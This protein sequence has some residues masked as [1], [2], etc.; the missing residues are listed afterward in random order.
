M[1]LS[2]NETRDTSTKVSSMPHFRNHACPHHMYVTFLLSV[3]SAQSID[4]TRHIEFIISV[5]KNL[6]HASAPP[7]QSLKLTKRSTILLLFFL[8]F[9]KGHT[10]VTA[11]LWS[12]LWQIQLDN[13]IERSHRGDPPKVPGGVAMPHTFSKHSW[14]FYFEEFVAVF[15][16]FLPS[17]LLIPQYAVANWAAP[18]AMNWSLPFGGAS[19][20]EGYMS[21]VR[22]ICQGSKNTTNN[23]SII[24]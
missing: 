3:V 8:K 15:S 20:V 2:L 7:F 13:K 1:V 4:E 12:E 18:H 16:N 9:L 22:V 17:T 24:K 19:R 14:T 11:E 23:K 21:R 6:F 10:V 5:A